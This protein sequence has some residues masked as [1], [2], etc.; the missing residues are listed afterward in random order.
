VPERDSN[1]S[2]VPRALS[3]QT[4]I[5]L[6]NEFHAGILE[7][8]LTLIENRM[9]SKDSSLAGSFPSERNEIL[10]YLDE[11]SRNELKATLWGFP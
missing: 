10:E 9:I 4:Q 5:Q 8:A 2:Q 1:E 11:Q 3:R 7:I 6:L